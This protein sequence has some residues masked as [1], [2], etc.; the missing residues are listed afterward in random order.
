MAASRDDFFYRLSESD[1][2]IHFR[3]NA[4]G[5][6]TGMDFLYRF[7]PADETGVKTGAP[8]K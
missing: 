2:R 1:S 3:R 5:K 7:G 8:P 4:E 6:I